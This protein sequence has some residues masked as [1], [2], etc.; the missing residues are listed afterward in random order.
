M[1]GEPYLCPVC[2]HNRTRF[3][4][5]IKLGRE[6]N[7]HADDGSVTFTDDEWETMTRQGRLDIEIRCLEC[8]HSADEREFARAA[9]RD[10]ER[11]PANYSR[12]A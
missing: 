3:V 8:D 6:I 7:K 12:R 1:K 11:I 2:R 5:I 9:R 4:Q 10:A